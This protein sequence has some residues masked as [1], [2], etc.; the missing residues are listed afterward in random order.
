MWHR[1]SIPLAVAMV[2]LTCETPVAPAQCS[3]PSTITTYSQGYEIDRNICFESADATPPYTTRSSDSDVA[4]ASVRG[5]RLFVVGGETG[6]ATVTVS[7]GQGD[8]LTYPVV[9]LDPWTQEYFA[10]TVAEEEED[11]EFYKVDYEAVVSVEVDLAELSL[12]VYIDNHL[13]GR[14]HTVENLKKDQEVS[15]FVGGGLNKRA[16]D[17]DL[18]DYD[19]T[20]RAHWIYAP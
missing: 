7:A 9:T 15:V 3:R 2:A 11:P 17:I 18:D 1:R 5:N 12:L 13:F 20:L 16:Y 19:C 14:P 10:C 4:T 6:D 8:A